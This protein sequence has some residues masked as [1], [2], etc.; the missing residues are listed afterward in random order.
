MKTSY[1]IALGI[2][3]IAAGAAA[4]FRVL[5]GSSV[6]GLLDTRGFVATT[7]KN[8]T[9]EMIFI[10]LVVAI[11]LFALFFFFAWKY[12]AGA[13]DKKQAAENHYSIIAEISL[14]VLPCIVIFL[15]SILTWQSAHR[16]D[17]YEKI[18]SSAQP[19]TIE[20]VALPWKWLFIYPAQNIATVNYIQFPEKTP[21]HFE[22][23]ADAPM[24]S[25][26]IPQLGTQIYAMAAMKTELNTV[27][28]SQGEFAGK[29]TEINGKGYAG[30]NFVAKASSQAEFDAWVRSV[31]Q[32]GKPLDQNAYDA[33]QVQSVNNTPSYYSS[34]DGDMFNSIM[35]KYMEPSGAMMP[36]MKM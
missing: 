33:L 36:G 28:D 21:V 34:V 35:M 12:R 27:A 8:L 7:E 1:K 22:L 29:N 24:S 10:M 15:I 18:N 25:F 13:T 14:W 16:L 11:P 4:F 30:M 31:Q 5:I 9:F 2:V 26:W 3:L 20:V 23:T 32:S 17:P 19:L 6:V